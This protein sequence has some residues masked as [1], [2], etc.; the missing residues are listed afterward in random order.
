[1]FCSNESDGD[2]GTVIERKRTLYG[3]DIDLT[4]KQTSLQKKARKKFCEFHPSMSSSSI[5]PSHPLMLPPP[6]YKFIP[7]SDRVCGKPGCFE[8]FSIYCVRCESKDRRI[9]ELELRNNELVK[10]ITLLQGQL[11]PRSTPAQPGASKP[12]VAGPVAASKPP[13]AGGAEPFAFVQSPILFDPA[14]NMNY[15][16]TTTFSPAK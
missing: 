3:V 14:L 15:V 9:V 5:P 13:A 8:C 10:H 16:A 11:F 6:G 7:N 4:T 1:M 2:S 12:G